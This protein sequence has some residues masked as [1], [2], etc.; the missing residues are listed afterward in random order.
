M[1]T[2]QYRSPPNARQRRIIDDCRA[3]TSVGGDDITAHMTRRAAD[4][5]ERY[6]LHLSA[7]NRRS[8]IKRIYI[9]V[10]EIYDRL[11]PPCVSG[12]RAARLSSLRRPDSE[13]RRF[14]HGRFRR[15]R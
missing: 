12:G 13:S 14:R 9:D 15:E 1:A 2:Y 7:G 3:N 6:L 4:N 10:I 5:R 11:L 8:G